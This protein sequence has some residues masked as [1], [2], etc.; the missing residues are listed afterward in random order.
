MIINFRELIHEAE[1]HYQNTHGGQS[2]YALEHFDL[3][4]ES[5]LETLRDRAHDWAIEWLGDLD[6]PAIN[7]V[8]ADRAIRQNLLTAFLN[9]PYIDST[10]FY[11]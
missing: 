10:G 8:A 11:P 1:R 3:W 4:F 6:I 2:P 5:M 9:V 7:T